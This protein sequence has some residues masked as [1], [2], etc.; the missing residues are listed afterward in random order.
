MM[1]YRPETIRFS[2]EDTDKAAAMLLKGGLV[3]LP[4]ETVYGLAA[5]AE[6]GP[7]LLMLYEVKKRDPDKA[8]AVLVTG[9]EMVEK[10][11]QNIPQ[12]AYRLAEKY[13]PGP[14]TMVLPKS[15]LVPMETS[16]G[17]S[18]VAVRLP[19]HPVA[20]RLIRACG[21]PLAAPSGN[22]SGRPSP[23]TA[24]HML[25]DMDGRIDAI[26]DGGPC[27]VGVESTVLA[28]AEQKPRLLRPGGVTLE[29]LQR[30]VGA[31]TVDPAVLHKLA[32]GAQAASP[33]MKYK[34]YAPKAKVIL[35][36]GTAERYREFVNSKKAPGVG[37]L[38]FDEDQ[39][40]LKVPSVPYGSGNDSAAQARELFDALRE[41]DERQEIQLVYARCPEPEG[42]GMAVYNR[43][44]RAAG[45]EVITL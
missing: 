21:C 44:I 39:H 3:A 26:L 22:L 2:L 8:S 31:V 34:H 30:V 43:L 15:E 37:A 45:F 16:G 23:T 25:H 42:V 35:V 9:M 29:M 13:W 36:K 10:Y 19:A 41:L 38:C 18:T 32:D 20:N 28:L 4:T 6:D 17:L 27:G 40:L 11:C 14:L 1:H 33:G 7:A 5:S 12:G 24:R